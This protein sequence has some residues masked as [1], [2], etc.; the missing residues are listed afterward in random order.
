MKNK[1]IVVIGATGRQGQAVIKSL[2]K[3]GYNIRALVRN[4]EK[5]NELLNGSN[6]EIFKGDLKNIDSLSGLF[7][8][9]YGLYFALPFLKVSIEFGKTLLNTAKDSNL[10]HII[11]SSVGGA[12]RNTKVNHFCYKKEIEDYL[13]SLGMPYTIIRPVGYMDEFANPKSIKVITGLLNLYLSKSKKFQ[14]ISLQDIGRFVEIAFENPV[15]Y[16]SKE[17]EIAGDEL[18][19]TEVFEKIEKVKNVKIAPARIPGFVKF[20]LP[21]I[22]KQMFTF[23]EEDGWRA[24]LK[25]LREENPELLKYGIEKNMGYLSAKHRNAIDEHGRTEFI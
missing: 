17:I 24:D 12:D 2:I 19:L 5:A 10:E 8:N 4:P 20:I 14:L 1:L 7:N 3:K 6:V 25:S 9:A 22:L 15:K 18:T 21:K 23:Y 11:Y 13:K 16:I